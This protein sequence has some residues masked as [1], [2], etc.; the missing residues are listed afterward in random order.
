MAEATL[1]HN[2]GAAG[3]AEATEAEQ[4]LR[5]TRSHWGTPAQADA[6][7]VPDHTSP[8]GGHGLSSMPW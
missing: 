2:P 8:I 5:Q 4:Q 6:I 7:G 1:G 3:E